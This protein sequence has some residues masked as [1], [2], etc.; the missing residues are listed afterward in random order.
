MRRDRSFE[1]L[2]LVLTIGR[3]NYQKDSRLLGK[4]FELSQRHLACQFSA[5]IDVEKTSEL[6]EFEHRSNA[7]G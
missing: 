4:L 1:S 6:D 3:R 5:I 7:F 2:L